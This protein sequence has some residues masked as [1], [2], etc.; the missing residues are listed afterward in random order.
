MQH[1]PRPQVPPR[2]T[3]QQIHVTMRIDQWLMVIGWLEAHPDC[4]IRRML[5]GAIQT[6]LEG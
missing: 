6:A 1:P 2:V 3:D 4:L 5:A